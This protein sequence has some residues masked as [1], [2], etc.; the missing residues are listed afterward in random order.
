M[1]NGNLRPVSNITERKLDQPVS[2]HHAPTNKC[3]YS[4]TPTDIRHRGGNDRGNDSRSCRMTKL[5]SLL[6]L[7]TKARPG[8][9]V[10]SYFQEH[11]PTQIPALKRAWQKVIKS[12]PMFRAVFDDEYF[13]E[14][15]TIC[16]L[17]S[18]SKHHDPC[19]FEEEFE[20]MNTP[21]MAE[22][23]TE[24]NIITLA[25]KRSIVVWHVHHALVDGYSARL[26]LQ[27]V[28]IV[29]NGGEISE[30]KSFIE[31]TRGWQ[32]YQAIFSEQARQFWR[33]YLTNTTTAN[34]DLLLPPPMDEASNNSLSTHFVTVSMPLQRV[35]QYSGERNLPL[36]SIYYAAWALVL[37]LYT[38]ADSVSFGVV[39]ANRSI[40]IPGIRETV[41]P[42]MNTLPLVLNLDRET[43]FKDLLQC[44]TQRVAK[45]RE[46]EWST[47]DQSPKMTS[48]LAM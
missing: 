37:A 8:N 13:T 20:S 42:M 48:V 40:P 36:S 18:E 3:Q 35:V 14:S 29:M 47:P 39:F 7:D 31:L 17:W 5:Q 44:T 43:K 30:G 4:P 26:L 38:G 10:I 16:F 15:D 33:D 24:F 28:S 32:M 27:R 46:F 34:H 11:P 22:P 1:P 6:V 12:E 25:G 21:E 41:G 19:S 2:F 23:A 45:L 9:N